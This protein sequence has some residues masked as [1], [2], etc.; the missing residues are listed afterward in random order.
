MIE[1]SD[2]GKI[3]MLVV[4]VG[5]VIYLLSGNNKNSDPIHNQGSLQQSAMNSTLVDTDSLPNNTDDS[6]VDSD[7]SNSQSQ[8]ADELVN[9]M[10]TKNSAGGKYKKSNYTGGNRHQDT[11]LDSFF[12][13]ENPLDQKHD[14]FTSNG[15]G[16]NY[17]SYTSGKEEKQTDRSKFDSAALLPKEQNDWFDD[18]QSK[19]NINSPHLINIYRPTGVN[20]IQT[21]L[22]NPSWDIRGAPANPKFVASPWMNSSYE[23]DTNIKNGA[24]CT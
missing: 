17:A 23:P 7:D 19:K 8:L 20:T 11:N 10:T 14:G 21:S 6:S 2:K 1:I 15:D 13:N 9:K 22:K 4:L 16:N 12:S 3:L 5:F 18:P 24:L